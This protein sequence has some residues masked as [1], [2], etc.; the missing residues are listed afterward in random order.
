[1]NR[2]EAESLTAVVV[3]AGNAS[4][5]GQDKLFLPLDR[6]PVL[7]WSLRAL[8]QSPDV[9]R[10]VIVL[11]EANR[12]RGRRLLV[13]LN[14]AKG[15]SVCAG[16]SRRQDS[17]WNGLQATIGSQW[18]AIHDGARPFLTADLLHRGFAAARAIG[19][20]V[21]AVPVKDT[22][23]LVD[24]APLVE[25]TPNRS[26]LWAAQTPQIFQ[27]D[28]LVEAYRSN[29]GA[30][31]TDDAELL[32]RAGLPTAV[33]LGSYENVKITTPDDL[34]LA[35]AIARHRANRAARPG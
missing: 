13:R 17:V 3:A 20:A 11:S 2:G 15:V 29:A 28:Q 26:R 4:R 31:V 5:F 32:E 9:A 35:R 22:I 16:G 7:G 12:E 30:D 21:A 33:Y 24:V 1:M 8:D 25:R 6:L 19:A 27:R 10:I 18:V 23:K 34:M 14:L